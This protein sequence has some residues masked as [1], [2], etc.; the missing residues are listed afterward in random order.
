MM[1][2]LYRVSY[3]EYITESLVFIYNP[4]TYDFNTPTHAQNWATLPIILNEETDSH[5]GA[6]NSRYNRSENSEY[7]RCQISA[8]L[9]QKDNSEGITSYNYV[10]QLN[11]RYH[12]S[13]TRHCGLKRTVQY[14]IKAQRNKRGGA[15]VITLT[16]LYQY[17]AHSFIG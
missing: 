10:W 7:D 17:S 3:Q 13:H 5:Y 8:V 9:S 14:C 15:N 12:N 6:F 16:R 4:Y 11:S 1:E 2:F